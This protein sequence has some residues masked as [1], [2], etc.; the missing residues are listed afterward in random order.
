MLSSLNYISNRLVDHFARAKT[1]NKKDPY[2]YSYHKTATLGEFLD[3]VDEEDVIGNNLESP[4]IRT[5]T[6]Q[7]IK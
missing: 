6:P 5:E 3:M 2:A 7:F 1:Y 4:G